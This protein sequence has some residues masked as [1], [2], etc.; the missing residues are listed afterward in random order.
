MLFETEIDNRITPI[1][2]AR[3]LDAIEINPEAAAAAYRERIVGPMRGKLPHK[4]LR[5]IE[6]HLSGACT[7]EIT[8]FDEFTGL[9][10]DRELTERYDHVV[11]DTAPTG[12]TIR[13]LWLAVAWSDFLKDGRGDASLPVHRCESA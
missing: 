2:G 7:T 4:V 6:E 10:T 12:H 9:L 8:A 5:N 13:L 11:F 3:G 1:E